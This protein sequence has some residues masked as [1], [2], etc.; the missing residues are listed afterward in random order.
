MSSN[1][2][3]PAVEIA[4]KTSLAELCR[5]WGVVKFAEESHN[6]CEDGRTAFHDVLET[7]REL[8]IENDVEK[9]NSVQIMFLRNSRMHSR[10]S[11]EHGQN[12]KPTRDDI[13]I[14]TYPK[15]GTTWTTQIVHMLRSGGDMNFEEICEVVPWD[16]LALDCGQDLYGTQNG[17]SPRIFKSH[18]DWEHIAGGGAPPDADRGIN[19]AK[20]IYVARNPRDAFVSFYNFMPAYVG[21]SPG[22]MT[23]QE[24]ADAIFG[25]VSQ[26]GG[27]W[28]HFLSF[29]RVRKRRNVLILFFEDLKEDLRTNVEI[30]AEFMGIC[31]RKNASII[32][33]AVRKS[34]YA[35]MREHAN[36]FDDHFV[37]DR[38]K[39][40]MGLHPNSAFKVGK[41]RK[42]GGK[43]GS[44]K[45]IPKP[46]EKLLL[47]MWKQTLERTTGCADYESFRAS[48]SRMRNEK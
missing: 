24:F 41:V 29:W 15:C 3:P 34:Q 32:D 33:A 22:S 17:F 4:C 1:G 19:E 7:V 39:C 21:I 43:V 35:F 47:D 42:G 28:R 30:I 9:L 36:Q 26:A 10:E 14:T 31:P 37:F 38:I 20:Y 5:A 18:E 11:V 16:I 23:M 48:L 13:F 45:E 8:A 46:V 6:A 2:P 40:R 12:F 44:R 25:G 27:I